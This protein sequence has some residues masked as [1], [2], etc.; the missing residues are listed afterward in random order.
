MSGEIKV[1]TKVK[2]KNEFNCGCLTCR[3]LE[4]IIATVDE[5]KKSELDGTDRI[6]FKDQFNSSIW[7]TRES[8]VEILP[9]LPDELFEM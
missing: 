2:L 8:I 3:D 9:T 7:Y 1:G 5:I 6:Q 4:G